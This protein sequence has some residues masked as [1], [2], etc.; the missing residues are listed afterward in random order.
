MLLPRKALARLQ[1]WKENSQG[2]TALLIIGAAGVG[3][4]TLVREFA[5]SHYDSSLVI[6]FAAAP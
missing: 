5:R 3:K 1:Q 2:R 6:D 4:S